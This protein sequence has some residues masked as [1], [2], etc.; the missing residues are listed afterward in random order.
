[1]AKNK[2]P[3]YI[4]AGD[5]PFLAWAKNYRQVCT[6]NATAW[7]LPEQRLTCEPLRKKTGGTTLRDEKQTPCFSL[8]LA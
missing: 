4:P 8:F 1:M 3:D 7:G 6:E 5:Y 2:K